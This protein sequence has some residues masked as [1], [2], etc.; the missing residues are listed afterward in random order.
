MP[1]KTREGYCALCAY[2]KSHPVRLKINKRLYVDGVS[3][4]SIA[5]ETGLDQRTVA[6]HVKLQ[7]GAK[8]VLD[9]VANIKEVKDALD[10]E[11]CKKKIWDDAQEAVDFALGR[12]PMPETANLNVFGQCIAPQV[13]LVEVMAKTSSG[14]GTETESDG[15]EEALKAKAKD[16]WKEARPV[17]MA[18]TEHE[19]MADDDLV[20]T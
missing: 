15:F 19:A 17:Q 13:K 9:Q 5:K 11:K 6:R 12:K 2:I 18:A 14:D 4:A 7:H 8:R 20:E 16:V 10:L 3:Y 1:R